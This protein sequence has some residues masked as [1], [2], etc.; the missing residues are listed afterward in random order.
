MTGLDD[1]RAPAGCGKGV[2]GAMTKEVRK[3]EGSEEVSEE[4]RKKVSRGEE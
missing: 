3:E 2:R 1:R 4:V